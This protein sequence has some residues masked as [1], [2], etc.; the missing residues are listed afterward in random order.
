M[1]PSTAAPEVFNRAVG[2]LRAVRPRHEILLEEI[3]APK[4]LAPYAF[5]QSAAVV[6]GED[7]VATG[8]LILL[9]DP[10]GHEAW[11][12]ALRLVTYIT[13]EI[14]PE[15][16][17]DPLLPAVG[18][19]WL[20]D[21][22]NTAH[23]EHVAI[24]GTVTQTSSTRFGELAGA[25]PA[26]DLEIRASWTPVDEDLSAHLDGWCALLGS[27]AGLPPPGVARLSSG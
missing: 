27:A 11:M 5:A 10:A 23:A 12:G 24:G 7:E 1:V 21:A 18:W 22:L 25:P 20:V 2:S 26:A 14:E 3:A 13:A 8:R 15:M 17:S 16:A 9:H 6:R 4:R 19:S